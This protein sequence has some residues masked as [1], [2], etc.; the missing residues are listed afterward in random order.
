MFVVTACVENSVKFPQKTYDT[1][2]MSYLSISFLGMYP[3]PVNLGDTLFH[4]I[5]VGRTRAK[6]SKQG[7]K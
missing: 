3:N 2:T 6:G 1:S 4:L 7:Q 5:S